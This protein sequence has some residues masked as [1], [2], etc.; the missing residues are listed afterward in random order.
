[1]G[2]IHNSYFFIL[3]S[4][5][6]NAVRYSWN[7]KGLG[8]TGFARHYYRH[9]CLLSL[10][11]GTKMFQFPSL[12]LLILW[13]QISATKHNS[14]EVSPFGHPRLKACRQLPVAFRSQ[15]RPS[16]VSYVKA[17]FMC[18][19]VTYCEL[20]H[21]ARIIILQFTF[22]NYLTIYTYQLQLQWKMTN[23]N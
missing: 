2:F 6:S 17:S 18:A 20:A 15:L 4:A 7:I 14:G 8:C 5:V 19:W 10:P 22:H 1:M 23:E 11:L 13:I 9:R 21:S 16:S 12:P 3:Y